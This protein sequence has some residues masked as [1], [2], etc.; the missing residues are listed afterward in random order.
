MIHADRDNAGNIPDRYATDSGEP[1]PD[2]DTLATGDS[3]D[4]VA[5]GLARSRR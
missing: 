5:C 1:G 4:R 2:E 3:G